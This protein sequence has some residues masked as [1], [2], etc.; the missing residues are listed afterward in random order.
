MV[1]KR[2]GGGMEGGNGFRSI[3]TGE[4]EKEYV[5][6]KSLSIIPL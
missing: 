3:Y 1:E 6:G 2:E 5:E 4:V